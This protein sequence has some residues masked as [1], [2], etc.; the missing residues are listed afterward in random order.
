[1]ARQR[2][3]ETNHSADVSY[4]AV[5]YSVVPDSVI[6]VTD[7]DYKAFIKENSERFKQEESTSIS[8]VRFPIIPSASDTAEVRAE[9]EKLKS[10]FAGAPQDSTYVLRKTRNPF[11]PGQ[12]KPMSELAPNMKDNVLNMAE[13]EVI[14]PFLEGNY[15]KL[16]KLVATQTSDDQVWN[17][18]KL[19]NFIKGQTPEDSI[20]ARQDALAALRTATYQRN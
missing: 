17:R 5:N 1:M 10:G 8:F 2:Y 20:K 19:V 3:I 13:K 16:Y 9:V 4:M 14:G 12:F 15:Y 18:I 6:E 7:G 11:I